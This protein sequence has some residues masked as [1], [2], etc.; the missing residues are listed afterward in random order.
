VAVRRHHARNPERFVHGPPVLALPP[1]EVLI[2]PV[3]DAKRE[4]GVVHEVNFPTL[5][6]AAAGIATLTSK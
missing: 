5:P 4:A 6:T 1:A 2:N 3:T